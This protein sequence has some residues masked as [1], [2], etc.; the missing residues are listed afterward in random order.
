MLPI[1]SGRPVRVELRPDLGLYHAAT[2]IPK[3]LILLDGG[4]LK[5]HLE[6]DRVVVHELFHFVWVRLSNAT[7]R[8]WEHH[9]AGE[10]AAKAKGELGWS[11][12]WR[13]DELRRADVLARTVRWRHYVC[14]SFC[15]SA[16]W[17]YAEIGRHP[18]WTLPAAFRRKRGAWF[19]KQFPPGLPVR[20]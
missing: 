6:F 8:E 14:E 19:G 7:R 13:K 16:A 2:S 10:I 20:F 12:E 9:L 17:L 4:V 15:D 18:E 1:L 3:R 11:A 5:E